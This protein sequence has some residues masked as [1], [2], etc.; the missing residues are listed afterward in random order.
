MASDTD[1][2]KAF[3]VSVATVNASRNLLVS[4]S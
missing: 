3:T 1:P 4:V 2:L